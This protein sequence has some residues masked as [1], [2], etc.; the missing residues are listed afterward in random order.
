MI[1]NSIIFSYKDI[2]AAMAIEKG[3]GE[4]LRKEEKEKKVR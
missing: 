3:E 2:R 4:R 1:D